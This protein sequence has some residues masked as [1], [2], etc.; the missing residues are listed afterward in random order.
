MRAQIT[1]T[2]NESERTIVKAIASLPY[3]QTAL[4]SKKIFLKGGT[5][6]SAVCEELVGQ[7]LR[8]SGRVVRGG[9]KAPRI[10]LMDRYESRIDSKRPLYQLP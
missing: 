7:P 9:T 1:L 2:V 6:V 8:I 5:T 10:L 4:K 3:V